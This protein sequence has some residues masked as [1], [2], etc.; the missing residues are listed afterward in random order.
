[1]EA[2]VGDDR[3]HG[4]VSHRTHP[5][6]AFETWQEHSHTRAALAEQKAGWGPLL[7]IAGLLCVLG[8]GPSLPDG[9]NRVGGKIIRA[10]DQSEMVYVAG[11]AALLTRD[12]RPVHVKPFYIDTHEVI[13][14]KYYAFTRM[15]GRVQPELVTNPAYA[16]PDQP[17]VGVT[18]EDAIAYATWCGARL[19]TEAEWEKAARGTDGRQ[20]PWGD[21]EPNRSRGVF[22]QWANTPEPVGEHPKGVSPYGCHNL[23]GNVAEWCQGWF[24]ESQDLGVIRGGCFGPFP[25]MGDGKAAYQTRME[26]WVRRGVAPEFP[27]DYVGFRCVVG[28]Q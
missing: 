25:I 20:F 19:P 3:L 23:A 16:K 1:M 2:L 4:F 11:G 6:M 28:A 7:P 13:N 5:G 8:C 24:D 26:C 27:Y 9:L 10:R 18:L 22:G 15:T 14:A 21:E 12:N 17:V